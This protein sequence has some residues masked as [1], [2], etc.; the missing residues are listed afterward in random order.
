MENNTRENITEQMYRETSDHFMQELKKKDRCI[1]FLKQRLGDI[2]HQKQYLIV[3]VGKIKTLIKV[4][5]ELNLV[6][7]GNFHD[8]A[9]ELNSRAACI[10]DSTV[11]IDGD[12][13]DFIENYVDLVLDEVEGFD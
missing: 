3:L 12:L 2:Q 13:E 11:S 4:H 5:K 10:D 6:S 8:I 1:Q 9:D 7:L